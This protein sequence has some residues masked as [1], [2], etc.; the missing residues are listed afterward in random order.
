V[1]AGTID[2]RRDGDYR[3]FYPAGRFSEFEQVA[4]GYLRRS[5]PRGMLVELL[6]DPSTTGGEIADALGVSRATVSA[7]AKDLDEAG[8]LSR[9]GGYAVRRPETLIT[10]LVRYADSFGPEAV[11]FA[12]EAAELVRYDPRSGTDADPS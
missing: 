8:L 10:L 11:A 9:E 3:R 4:L 5:T 1:D 12:G 6:R 2:S 7:H